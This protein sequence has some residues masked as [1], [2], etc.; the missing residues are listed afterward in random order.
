VVIIHKNKLL[1]NIIM[2]FILATALH[3]YFLRY[4]PDHKPPLHSEKRSSMQR[5]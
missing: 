5:A 3:S 1:S 2:L 4:F